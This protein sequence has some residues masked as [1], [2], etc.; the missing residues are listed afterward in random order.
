MHAH[1]GPISE[2]TRASVFRLRFAVT[3][4]LLLLVYALLRLLWY[5]DA[6]F[7]I[8]VPYTGSLGVGS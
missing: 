1:M 5:P 2:M 8:V 4:G 6:Y 7:D 3:A